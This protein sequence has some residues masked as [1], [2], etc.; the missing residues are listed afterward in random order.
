MT[1]CENKYDKCSAICRKFTLNPVNF[2]R[3]GT[4]NHKNRV[5]L[6]AKK[7]NKQSEGFA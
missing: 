7:F 5:P 1:D 2:H 4:Y 6:S 3:N